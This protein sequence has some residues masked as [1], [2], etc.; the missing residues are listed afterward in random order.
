M[1]RA[2]KL[3]KPGV[4][5]AFSYLFDWVLCIVLIALF[6]M[7]DN[8]TPF[9]RQFSVEDTSLMYPYKEKETIP[10]WALVVISIIFPAV[11]MAIIS[12]AIRRSIYDFHNG[13]LGLLLS[14][15]LT[16]AVTQVVKV[17]V[18]K[19]RP[20]FLSR[21]KPMINGV[22]ITQN[23]PLRLWTVDICTTTNYSIFKDGLRSFPSGHAS[24]SF[25]GLLYLSFWLAGK[26]HVFDRKGYSLK[27][28]LL[29]T[30]VLTAVLVTI[31]RLEDYRHDKIDVLWGMSIG[32]FFAFFAYHQYYP[33]ITKVHSHIPHPP[34]D[35]SY[36]IKDDEGKVQEAGHLEA[37]TGIRPNEES[38]D[39]TQQQPE[40]P[41]DLEANREQ[42]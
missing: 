8:L 23:E 12:L 22:P 38:I 25:A 6:L 15:S 13:I 1:D 29:M 28:V 26:M 21:C 5:L 18:G 30:P 31:S 4:R 11:M 27:S 32:T 3:N 36:L 39:E 35:F 16:I 9:K 34:R 24:T 10:T 14:A 37:L 19:H 40:Q 41:S 33:S 17:T 2:K 20:D 42:S 7:L